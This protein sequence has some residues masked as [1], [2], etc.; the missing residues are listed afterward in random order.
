MVY[1]PKLGNNG[2][3]GFVYHS[4]KSNYTVIAQSS[5]VS[6]SS[7]LMAEIKNMINSIKIIKP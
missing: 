1:Y 7:P 2:K 4:N 5:F 3:I 6:A